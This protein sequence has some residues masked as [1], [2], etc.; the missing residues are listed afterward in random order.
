M[1]RISV[2]LTLF[3][4]G[5][6]SL[7]GA[8]K[9]NVLMIVGD[10]WG[11]PDFGFMG[12]KDVQTPHLN[13][14]AKESAVFPNGYVPTSL[15]RASL[16]TLLT[17]QFAHQHKICCNDPPN[18]V[19][20]AEMLP[21]LK[22]SPTI[23]RLLKDASYH[24]FQTGKFWEGHFSNGAFTDGM[25]T[26]G[27]HGEEGL[28]IGRQTLK[29]IFNFIEAGKDP[30]FIWYAPMMPHSPHNPPER[31]LKK[32]TK[33]GRDPRLAAYYAMCE[34]T[35]ETIGELLQYLA[36]KKLAE[37]TIILFVVDNGWIQS[38]GPVK[39]GDQFLTRSKNTP[40]DGG[41]RTPVILKWPGKTKPGRY[42]DLVSTVDLAPTLLE[43]CGVAI[44]KAIAGISLLDPATGKGKL[45]RDAVFGEIYLHTAKTL[46]NPAINLTHR[47]V[48]SGD[49]KLILPAGGKTV[50]PELYNLKDDPFETKDVALN[51]AV[52]I[53]RLTTLMIESWNPVWKK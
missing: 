12:S 50:E 14:L 8:E 25:T 33:E 52:I 46:D 30:W 5:A 47:W 24:S 17:G 22:N 32:Y 34:W 2:A 43:A 38:Q 23:P 13:K 49:W 10:D 53:T 35:D 36:D 16:A 40:Y 19:D 51:N 44:P 26:K 39:V 6:N 9:P 7:Q 15:C 48:R 20:R 21:F 1:N 42:D 37:N 29:P 27:R 45:K 18:G 3:L 31:L 4:L 11:W 41:V 28:V